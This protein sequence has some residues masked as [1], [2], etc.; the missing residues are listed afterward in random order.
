MSVAQRL[1]ESGLIT[2]MRTDSLNLSSLALGAAKEQIV[3]TMGTEY[4]QFR[5]YHT[6]S[7]GAQEAH[8]AIR[9]TYMDRT[10]IQGT[11]EERRLYDL[12][13]KR[14]VACQMADAQLER[15]QM[16]IGV[17][18]S[19][20]AFVATGEVVTFDGFLRVYRESTDDEQ[21]DGE[22][23][24]L[25]PQV[26]IGERLGLEEAEAKLRYSQRPSRF[27]EASLVKKMEELGIGRPSTYAPTISTIQARGYVER[28]DREPEQR[29]VVHL[30]LKEG[31]IQESTERETYGNDRGK[32]MPT[33]VGILVTDFLQ[34]H[35]PSILEYN[36][37]ANVEAEFDKIADGQE[38]WATCIEEFY[39][40]FHPMVTSAS[41]EFTDH[42]VGERN[43]GK[44][45]KTGLTVLA[46]VGQFGPMAQLGA[47]DEVEKPKFASLQ[48]GQ[49]IY[50]ITLEEALS[51][52][53]LPKELGEFEGKTVTVAA[54]R[55]GPYVKHDG[56]FVSLEKG[57]DP[58]DVTLEQAIGLIEAKREAEAKR[59]IRTFEEDPEMQLLNG[60][61]GAYLCRAGK[62][63]RLPHKGKA[64]ELSYADCLQIIEAAESE[65]KSETKPR[66][67]AAKKSASATTKKAATKAKKSTTT[68][69]KEA[70]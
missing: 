44:D 9:P 59:V 2:Y 8:E 18:G 25:L 65:E 31:R 41:D 17:G 53:A 23:S 27:S 6:H 5:T 64:E 45:P 50:T 69:K 57:M 40:V 11:A 42:R 36:F 32:L 48:K 43:L 3:S 54:G 24:S 28:F 39:G 58:L 61:F 47:G 33:D 12:I 21:T 19:D 35:F 60:R 15:T 22:D 1:Y 38:P 67:T 51:L 68:K 62:N 20:Y 16:T 4:H 10:S 7:K 14:T 46:K 55:F 37:T 26:A 52:F 66:R 29:D 34:L 56:K 63:Y 13:W 70:E 30:R 49:S